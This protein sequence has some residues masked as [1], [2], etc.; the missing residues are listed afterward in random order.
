ML[1][2]QQTATG[3]VKFNHEFNY[4]GITVMGEGASVMD[5]AALLSRL[6]DVAVIDTYYP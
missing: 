6:G 3:Y 1:Q 2:S 4:T 5:S